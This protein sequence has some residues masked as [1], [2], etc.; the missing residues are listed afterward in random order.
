MQTSSPLETRDDDKKEKFIYPSSWIKFG[1]SSL[2]GSVVLLIDLSF[3]L[4]WFF[5]WLLLLFG[6]LLSLIKMLLSSMSS[7]FGCIRIKGSSATRS[8]LMKNSF[9]HL[10]GHLFEGRLKSYPPK[11]VMHSLTFTLYCTI[12]PRFSRCDGSATL[13][14]SRSEWGWRVKSY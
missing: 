11:G 8:L 9:G 10:Q 14:T 7:G 4:F 1:T 6:E 3:R 2:A 12:I 13:F 5:P